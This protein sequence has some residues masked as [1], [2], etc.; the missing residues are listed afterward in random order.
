MDA[1][2][3][4]VT[5]SGVSA[6]PPPVGLPTNLMPEPLTKPIRSSVPPPRA[7]MASHGGGGAAFGAQFGGNLLGKVEGGNGVRVNVCEAWVCRG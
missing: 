2:D 3:A 7:D 4:Q 1:P 5:N 6:I